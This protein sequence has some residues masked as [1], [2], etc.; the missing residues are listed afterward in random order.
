MMMKGSN[1][2][3]SSADNTHRWGSESAQHAKGRGA[4]A[5]PT[6]S[7]PPPCGARGPQPSA[8]RRRPAIICG[9][10]GATSQ[11]EIHPR[12]VH[13]SPRSVTQRG[14]ARVCVSEANAQRSARNGW[15]GDPEVYS[16]LR[17]TARTLK[18]REDGFDAWATLWLC[19]WLPLSL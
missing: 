19:L 5:T 6:P 15:R 14:R 7:R 13:C 11:H 1:S 9:A 3:C 10:S 17:D 4:P 18:S 8:P 12:R 2:R 16:G